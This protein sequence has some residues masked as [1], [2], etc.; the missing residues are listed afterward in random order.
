MADCVSE[1]KADCAKH[2]QAASEAQQRS[3]SQSELGVIAGDRFQFFL[4]EISSHPLPS[5]FDPGE[6]LRRFAQRWL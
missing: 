3:Q 5:W 2:E 4:A 1:G 6:V